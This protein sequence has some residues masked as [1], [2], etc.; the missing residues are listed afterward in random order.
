MRWK[1]SGRTWIRKRR[2]ELVDVERHQVVAVVGLGPVILP[3]ERH[4]LA[5]EGDEP[6]VGNSDPVSVARQVG[7]HSAGSAKGPLGIDH[8][9]D[10]SQCGN[11]GFEG[12]RLPICGLDPPTMC[13]QDTTFLVRET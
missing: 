8:P 11:V 6:A 3:F 12:C 10:L 2:N 5:V 4:G 1:A 13:I 7:D 9:F